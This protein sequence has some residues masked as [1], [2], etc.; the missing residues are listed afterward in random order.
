MTALEPVILVRELPPSRSQLRQYLPSIRDLVAATPSADEPALLSYLGQ[1]VVCGIYNDPGLLRDVL[2][3]GQRID[4]VSQNDP[5]LSGL[6]IQP[7]LMLTDGAWVWPGVLPYYVAVYHLRLPDRFLRFAA[8]HNWK[9][10]SG[11]NL[12]ELS[13]DEYDAVA[14]PSIAVN[15]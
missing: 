6:T 13:W 2:H 1:G 14:D 12:D 11:I 7:S 8:E 5:R 10:A 9:I 15:Q 3:A 4:L